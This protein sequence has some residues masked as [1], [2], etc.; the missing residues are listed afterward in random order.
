MMKGSMKIN[1]ANRTAFLICLF[2]MVLFSCE[3]ILLE[4]DISDEEVFLTAPANNAQFF[5]TGVSFSWEG[6]GGGASYR[7]Q[8]A[9]PNFTNPMEIVL[10]TVLDAESFGYQLNIGDYEWRVKA[11]NTGYETPYKSRF[12]TIVSN[13]DFQNNTVSLISPQNN[14]ITLNGNQNLSWQAVIGATE[15]QVQVYEGSTIFSDQTIS[16]TTFD[17]NFPEGSFQWRVRASNGSQQTLY[18][19][20]SILVD[21]TNP[22]TPTLISPGNATS[23]P[24]EDIEFQW[25]R[26]S[27][28]GSTES[29]SIYVY[30]DSALS[31][32]VFK[33]LAD[34]NPYS[35]TTFFDGGT[36]YYWFM[37][38][39]DEAGNVSGQSTVFSFTVD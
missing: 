8:V 19:S 9:R 26:Q 25:S 2:S 27:V 21:S 24:A 5:S 4:D 20:R 28:A 3:E 29:D 31:N 17:Y 12:F 36:T 32:L 39:F 33:D 15:Y 7:L 11:L 6:P 37:K 30:H 1:F 22:N 10:D 14:L 38:A 16:G 35:T 23:L 13:E 18:S 34:D